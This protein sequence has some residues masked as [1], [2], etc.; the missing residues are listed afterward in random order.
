MKTDSFHNLIVEKL[1]EK[2]KDKFSNIIKRIEARKIL[3][4]NHVPIRLHNNF[5]KEMVSL[6][7]I[8]IK[9]KQN[10]EILKKR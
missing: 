3:Y 1:L 8:R 5:F 9:D 7:L 4:C 6:K 10:I 2:K